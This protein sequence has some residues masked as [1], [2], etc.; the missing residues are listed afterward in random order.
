M[1]A[2][3]DEAQRQRDAG[4]H[5]R[6]GVEERD[7]APAREADPRHAVMEVL[8]VGPI[9]RLLVLQPLEQHEGRVEERHREQDQRQHEGHDGGRLDRRLDDHDSHQQPEQVGAAVAHEARRG[10]EVE[11]QEAERGAGGDR[12]QHA[13]LLTPEV[14]R[15]HGHRAGDD[16]ADPRRQAVDPVGEVDDVHQE[17]EAEHGDDRP[18]VRHARVG[19]LEFAGE[20]Q[21]DRLH[22]DAVM[23]DDHRREDLAGELRGRVQLVAVIERAD[24]GDDGRREQHAVPQLIVLAVARGQKGQDRD[25]HP[26]ED[27]EA[28]EQRRRL[29]REAALARLVDGADSPCQA[30]REGREQRRH[31]ERHA[32][33]RTALRARSG[34]PSAPHSIA[35]AGVESR[36]GCRLAGSR[37]AVDVV[38][39]RACTDPRVGTCADPGSAACGRS[40]ER[41][42]RRS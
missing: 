11:H 10:R 8:A 28:A 16:R 9:D 36:R 34:A 6:P 2:V 21:R 3:G 4:E 19:E 5:Q 23:D 35:G 17:D 27:R 12:G 33:T 15:D 41:R 37:P 30:H 18:R 20:R 1:V 38:R 24:R 31:G 42:M 25:E 29:L 14:E 39:V 13:G 7:R 40:E 32:G 26:P 22:R